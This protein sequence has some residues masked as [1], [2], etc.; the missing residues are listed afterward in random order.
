MSVSKAW[1]E[2]CAEMVRDLEAEANGTRPVSLNGYVA[3][4]EAW[5]DGL[6]RDQ[7]GNI[8]NGLNAVVGDLVAWY[9][10]PQVL[11]AAANASSKRCAE[12]YELASLAAQLAALIR[13][14]VGA[15][16]DSVRAHVTWRGDRISTLAQNLTEADA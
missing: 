14:H 8:P 6:H 3:R 1:S 16:P 2:K 11:E 4:C 10:V 12:S 9:G 15:L 7:G 13:D 5:A